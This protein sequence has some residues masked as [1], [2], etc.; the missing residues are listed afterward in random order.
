MTAA[1]TRFASPAGGGRLTLGISGK[2]ASSSENNGLSASVAD[3]TVHRGLADRRLDWRL[4]RA[5]GNLL[6]FN[7]V[8]E[9]H[10][11][12]VCDTVDVMKGEGGA[13]FDGVVTCR[14]RWVCAVCARRLT[15]E[16]RHELQLAVTLWTAQGGRVYLL[17][18]TFPHDLTMPLAD[19]L[20]R[21]QRAQSRMKGWTAYKAIMAEAGAIGAVKALECTHGFNG[22][23]PHVHMLVFAKPGMEETLERVRA[24][25]EKA[26]EKAGLG[27]INEHGFDVR[28]GD[29]AAEY[30]AKYGREPSDETRRQQNSWW[31]ASHEL[32]KGHAKQGQRM[33]GATPFTLL[34][35]YMENGDHQ[36]GALFA[37][38][39]DAFQGRAQLYWSP[40][41]RKRVDLLELEQPRKEPAPPVKVLSLSRADWHAVLRHEARWEVLYVAERYGAEAVAELLA[42]MQR[43]RGRWQGQFKMRD[44]ASGRWYAGYWRPAEFDR[45]AA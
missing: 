16:A 17:T 18:F 30:V 23:H 14:Q 38:Y 28:G 11:T 7:R 9:C 4:M 34:R 8:R 19:S 44:P 36:A 13:H 22:W 42:G 33:K 26:V 25:W 24:Q 6:D 31:T 2:S 29:H 39:A 27:K 5:A 43:S 40:G 21:M 12:L 10:R 41:L 35:W 20:E 1:G 45:R 15:D 3:L 32:T 37:E